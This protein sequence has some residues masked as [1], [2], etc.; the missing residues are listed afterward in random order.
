MAYALLCIAFFSTFLLSSSDSYNIGIISAGFP[1]FEISDNDNFIKREVMQG[2]PSSM[3]DAIHGVKMG[4]ASDICDNAKDG[5]EI[6]WDGSPVNYTCYHPKNRLP[7]LKNV[8]SVQECN[9]P[10]KFYSKH[11]CLNEKIEYDDLIPTYGNHRPLWPVYGE[12]VYAPPQRWIH[13]LEHGAIVMLYHPCAEP[14]EVERLRQLVK[15]CL[16]R[17]VITPYMLLPADRPLALV[18]WGCKLQMSHVEEDVVKKFIKKN[19]LHGPEATLVKQGQYRYKLLEVAT[20]PKGSN[21]RDIKLC[22]SS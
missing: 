6:D 22:P 7:V 17:H 9:I 5:L 19:A 14:L 11:V 8:D 1:V 2:I 21:F 10:E 3:K 16:R 15:N 20:A 4:V 18:A 12:Y 13:N